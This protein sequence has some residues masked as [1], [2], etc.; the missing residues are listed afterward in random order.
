MEDINVSNLDEIPIKI[1]N[2]QKSYNDINIGEQLIVYIFSDE[3]KTIIMDLSVIGKDEN[4]IYLQD[5][6]NQNQ[7]E[8]KYEDFIVNKYNILDIVRE[9]RFLAEE[10]PYLVFKDTVENFVADA[11]NTEIQYIQR[12][13]YEKI[14]NIDEQEEDIYNFFV[15]RFDNPSQFTYMLAKKKA[16]IIGGLIENYTNYRD[17]EDFL[18][19]D[20]IMD[21]K[22]IS[23]LI[24]PIISD[25]RI[26]YENSLMYEE[27]DYRNQ[28]VSFGEESF[29]KKS[30]KFLE[31]A[32]KQYEYSNNRNAPL[33]INSRQYLNAQYGDEELPEPVEGIGRI[34][35]ADVSNNEIQIPPLRAYK[36]PIFSIDYPTYEFRASNTFDAYRYV[37]PSNKLII[38]EDK[39]RDTTELIYDV[40]RVLG[41]IY[42]LRDNP[43]E[44]EISKQSTI[45]ICVGCIKDESKYHNPSDKDVPTSKNNFNK[46]I[47]KPPTEDIVVP[48]EKVKLAGLVL[49]SPHSVIPSY[50]K[51]IRLESK[52]KISTILKSSEGYWT[53]MD[54]VIQSRQPK[55]SLKKTNIN[56][57]NDYS[58]E[59]IDYNKNN[60]I[61]L[62]G[63]T[64]NI[65]KD[66]FRKILRDIIPNPEKALKLEEANVLTINNITD[67][68]KILSKYFLNIK[69]LNIHLIHEIRDILND[70]YIQFKENSDL[71]KSLKNYYTEINKFIDATFDKI[72]K[73][74]FTIEINKD[75]TIDDITNLFDNY[76]KTYDVDLVKHILTFYFGVDVVYI[77]PEETRTILIQSFYN[78]YIDYLISDSPI[79][80]LLR[81]NV[82]IPNTF[83]QKVVNSLREFYGLLNIKHRTT[84]I[85]LINEMYHLMFVK[86]SLDNFNIF[87][88]YVYAIN[89]ISKLKALQGDLAS[90]ANKD[91]VNRSILNIEEQLNINGIIAYDRAKKLERFLDDMERLKIDDF[92]RKLETL[93]YPSSLKKI[94]QAALYYEEKFQLIKN[95]PDFDVQLSELDKFITNHGLL[96]RK[97]VEGKLERVPV[98]E[99]SWIYYDIPGEA[100]P[101]CCKHYLLLIKQ[102]WKSNEERAKLQEI[103]NNIWGENMPEVRYIFCKNC[104]QVLDYAKESEMEGFDESDKAIQIREAVSDYLE[105]EDDYSIYFKPEGSTKDIV[106]QFL[107]SLMNSLKMSLNSEQIFEIV[108]ESTEEINRNLEDRF[109]FESNLLI[110]NESPIPGLNPYFSDQGKVIKAYKTLRSSQTNY[111]IL[112]EEEIEKIKTISHIDKKR[113]DARAK[114]IQLFEKMM[115]FYDYKRMFVIFTTLVAKL[116]TVL[117][118]SD[119]E[120]K[121][122]GNVERTGRI[123][124]LG[125]YLANTDALITTLSEITFVISKQTSI[126]NLKKFSNYFLVGKNELKPNEISQLLLNAILKEYRVFSETPLFKERIRQKLNRISVESKIISV[127]VLTSS[128][129]KTFRPILEINPASYDSELEKINLNSI[130][131]QVSNPN[132]SEYDAKYLAFQLSYYLFYS[133]EKILLT[134]T[135]MEVSFRD[136]STNTVKYK[137][138][139]YC[140]LGSLRSKY[141]E[142]FIQK[143]SN[144][145]TCIQLMSK[146]QPKAFYNP[147]QQLVSIVGDTIQVITPKLLDYIE[148]GRK[149]LDVKELKRR[150]TNLLTIYALFENENGKRRVYSR[151]YDIYL[152]E[153]KTK[154][155][156]EIFSELK[157]SYPDWSDTDLKARLENLYNKNEPGL[158]VE[159][160]DNNLYSWDINNG[161]ESI[162]GNDD[163]EYL[164][165]VYDNLVKKI[166]LANKLFINTRGFQRVDLKIRYNDL[167]SQR[168]KDKQEL[169]DIL[170]NIIFSL[171]EDNTS[172]LE[173]VYGGFVNLV[174]N[175]KN[176]IFGDAAR[177]GLFNTEFS[178]DKKKLKQILPNLD[179]DNLAKCLDQEKE[180]IDG[181]KNQIRIENYRENEIEEQLKIRSNFIKYSMNF[182]RLEQLKKYYEFF[183]ILVLRF[184]YLNYAL[185]ALE[186]FSAKHY[187]EFEKELIENLKLDNI[188]SKYWLKTNIFKNPIYQNFNK[189]LVSEPCP[190]ELINKLTAFESRYSTNDSEIEPS[191]IS[192]NEIKYIIIY[193][194]QKALLGMYGV[195]SIN[196]LESE[197][198]L[199]DKKIESERINFVNSYVNYCIENELKPMN[200]RNCMTEKQVSLY[201]RELL[202]KKNVKKTERYENLKKE[203]M[204]DVYLL[205][206]QF[207]LGNLFG[208]IGFKEVD[209]EVTYMNGDEVML[210]K[211][212]NEMVQRLNREANRVLGDD[213]SETAV[214]LL[215]DEMHRQGEEDYY[216]ALETQLGRDS[217]DVEYRDTDNLD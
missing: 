51:L 203:G 135:L 75:I 123:R 209:E 138:S 2:F 89:S 10:E 73:A 142:F 14:Y 7:I 126:G 19:N 177:R 32:Y 62:N 189:I 153:I 146:L 84:R 13:E 44:R 92:K 107:K 46:I 45:K 194:I 8:W 147:S 217:D 108:D 96:N 214:G 9:A 85:G 54:R 74:L 182:Y 152:T 60:F 143:D 190:V 58:V 6:T 183:A 81:P 110:A 191:V 47:S 149:L 181:L 34:L 175:Y 71:E 3:T 137:F 216:E 184:K 111:S 23:P 170:N 87:N 124:S 120:I 133:I 205:Y 17:T 98:S 169:I 180:K 199:E 36:N 15:S 118:A 56:E 82:E 39:K 125:N 22:Y 132:L 200:D 154:T 64:K 50:N 119:P 171:S 76:I 25:T 102:A 162:L 48:G 113:E 134:E 18:L 212:S 57:I 163:R 168:E 193:F 77:S 20:L 116:S 145:L 215:I 165:G 38:P 179:L 88:D 204:E 155:R 130:A 144:I 99:S 148:E 160:L 159:D 176:N 43:D 52:T 70:R 158:I 198:T 192:T 167:E 86:D 164:L 103:L 11:I 166:Y 49:H 115:E 79:R 80:I 53:I 26:V 197:K 141:M 202:N 106:Y 4:T 101:M 128:P 121:I 27:T 127:R 95:I 136:P 213:A 150:I 114:F 131:N 195:V 93:D 173:N 30:L 201:L 109:T 29:T 100:I 31:D 105:D 178:E 206:R 112:N 69:N 185:Y 33:K 187:N 211:Q 90:I 35:T 65:T 59:T 42:F 16:H 61:Y 94:S 151:Y 186:G 41:P 91:L 156:D 104:G 21:N 139:N 188:S 68:N 78:R 174:D 210:E 208:D 117:I 196:K 72:Y 140:C 28:F 157:S 66:E 172:D 63:S 37:S 97:L 83:T 12:A 1:L 5:N 40:R 67:L 122:L 207:G 161:I 24:S 129:W 55:L